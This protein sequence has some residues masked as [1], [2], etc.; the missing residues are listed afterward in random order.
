[1]V[2]K[3]G[4]VVLIGVPWKQRCDATAFQV[5]HVVFHRYLVLRSG[6]EWEV[7]FQPREFM[8]G[9]MIANFR[10]ALRWLADGRLKAAGLYRKASPAD[11]G[12]VYDD[13][14]HG[15]GDGLSVVFEWAHK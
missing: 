13:L 15:R 3:R 6:W 7:P 4:E 14:F 8:S 5:M 11:A 1:M 12:R 2:R 9:S 10:G